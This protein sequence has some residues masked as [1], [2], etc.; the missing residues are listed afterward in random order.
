[1]NA[2]AVWAQALATGG[3]SPAVALYALATRKEP[4]NP[5]W[6]LLKARFELS[7]G[8]ARAALVDFYR[9]NALNPYANPS[10]GPDDY[11]RALA[12]VN[13]GRPRC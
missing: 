10:Q 11:R 6:W 2:E 13:T 9:F 5:Q 7:S 1:M 4:Q 12:L 8:C 3:Y